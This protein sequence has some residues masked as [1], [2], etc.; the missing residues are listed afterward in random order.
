MG[1][2]ASVAFLT[3]PYGESLD[4]LVATSLWMDLADVL[5]SYRTL[6]NRLGHL[7]GHIRRRFI[8]MDMSDFDS[9]FDSLNNKALPEISGDTVRRLADRLVHESWHPGG[10]SELTFRLYWKG[11]NQQTVDFAESNAR[12]ALD[13]LIEDTTMQLRDF[14]RRILESS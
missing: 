12:E 9:Q 2:P 8:S 7:R 5:V 10:T 3:G 6:V 1:A 4:Y 14:I 13:S 11:D